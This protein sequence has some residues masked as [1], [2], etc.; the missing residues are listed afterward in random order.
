LTSEG[1]RPPKA[2]GRVPLAADQS[3]RTIPLN[4]AFLATLRSLPKLAS[5]SRNALERFR[6]LRF[7]PFEGRCTF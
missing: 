4:R 3:V 7:S 5:V 1:S 6:Y 2:S